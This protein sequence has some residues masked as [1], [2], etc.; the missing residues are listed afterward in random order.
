MSGAL[1]QAKGKGNWVEVQPT[2]TQLPPF[3]AIPALYTLLTFCLQ[4]S[5]G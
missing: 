5:H 3:P 2:V 4:T 1:A